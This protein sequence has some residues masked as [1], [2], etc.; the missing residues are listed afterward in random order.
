VNDK[1][2]D[3]AELEQLDA[4]GLFDAAW[5]LAINP[6]V[7]DAGSQPLLHFCRYGWREGRWANRYFDPAWYL[8]CNPDVRAADVN[9]L[10]HYMRDGDREGRRPV[11]HFDS[12]WYRVA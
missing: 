5:Y 1:V 10:L 4:S 9:P 12:A 8:Q 7:R 6:D 3:P 2:D 11:W